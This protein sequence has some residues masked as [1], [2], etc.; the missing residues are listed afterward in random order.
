M[1]NL[2]LSGQIINPQLYYNSVAF[3][4]YGWQVISQYITAQSDSGYSSSNVQST[5]RIA[6]TA[7]IQ[8]SLTL[9]RTT[10]EKTPWCVI[11]QMQAMFTH[12]SPCKA[13]D[14]SSWSVFIESVGREYRFTDKVCQVVTCDIDCVGLAFYQLVRSFTKYLQHD[15]SSRWVSSLHQSRSVCDR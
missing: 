4:C 7:A 14:N 8:E 6:K 3:W 11:K 1:R 5:L 2:E 12:C 9:Y 10:R 15:I 13:H